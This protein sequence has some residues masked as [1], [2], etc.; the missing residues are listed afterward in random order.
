[1]RELKVEEVSV[2]VV[3]LLDTYNNLNTISMRQ[4]ITLL[5]LVLLLT[6]ALTRRKKETLAE[7]A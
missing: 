1:M 7:Q 2:R 4:I 6:P 5:L 3:Y